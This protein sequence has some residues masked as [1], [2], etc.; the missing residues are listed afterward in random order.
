MQA[1]YALLDLNEPCHA[2]STTTRNGLGHVGSCAAPIWIS[3]DDVEQEQAEE[4]VKPEVKEEVEVEGREQLKEHRS[5][6]PTLE[7][8][9]RAL[10]R[11][12]TAQSEKKM[13]NG[14]FVV[15]WLPGGGWAAQWEPAPSSQ[16]STRKRKWTKCR[17]PTAAPRSTTTSRPELKK[18]RKKMKPTERSRAGPWR[19]PRRHNSSAATDA[20][21]RAQPPR[22]PVTTSASASKPK[23]ESKGI[24]SLRERQERKWQETHDLLREW[25]EANGHLPGLED[26]SVLFYWMKYQ[27]SKEAKLAPDRVAK[28]R[29]LG[30]VPFG[31]R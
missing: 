13:K 25:A 17:M 2:T 12:P 4:H 7:K 16:R 27:R 15:S 3:D 1:P 29:D 28:L 6:T 8:P 21:A 22:A 19:S 24:V 18:K 26:S 31:R 5:S 20:A 23:Y 9:I 11:C 14:R 30:L 10:V